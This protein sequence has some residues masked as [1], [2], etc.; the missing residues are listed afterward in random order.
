MKHTA[1]PSKPKRSLYRLIIL[2]FVSQVVIV[3]GLT[4]YL[5][6]HNGQLAVAELASQLRSEITLR[7]QQKLI[8]YMETPHLIN[9]INADAVRTGSLDI[10][11][12]DA[13]RQH[14]WQ[15]SRIKLFSN[16]VGYIGLATEE[17]NYY[18]VRRLPDG[19]T[20]FDSLI[21]L[22]GG[23]YLETWFADEAGVY[24]RTETISKNPYDPRIRP[25]YLLAQNAEKQV[26]TDVF[27]YFSGKNIAISANQPLYDTKNEFVG[28]ASTDLMLSEISDFLKGLKIGKSGKT[29]IMER[30]GKLVTSSILASPIRYDQFGKVLSDKNSKVVRWLATE[31]ENE[32]IRTAAQHLKRHFNGFEHIKGTH[33][34]QFYLDGQK[35]FIQ[36]S[37]LDDGRGLDW[38]VVVVV[39]EADFMEHIYKN[40]MTTLILAGLALIIAMIIGVF[41]AKSITKPILS[42]NEAAKKLAQGQW[43]QNLPIQRGDEIGELA[44]SFNSMGQQLKGLIEN[45]EQKVAERTQQLSKAFKSLKSSQAQLVQSEKMASLGQMVAGVAHEINTPLGYVKGNVE[46]SQ[47]LFAVV[48]ELLVEFEKLH[49]LLTQ[50]PD[51]AALAQQFAVLDELIQSFHEDDVLDDIKEL[52]LDAVHGVQEI[53]KL[54]MNLKNFSRLD[55]AHEEDVD[56][57]KCIDS[58]LNI[59]HNLLKHKVEVKLQYADLPKIVCSPSQINQVLLNIITNAAQAIEGKGIILIKTHF[60]N[61]S[62]SVLIQDNGAGIDKAHLEKIFDPFFTTKPVGEGTGLGLS[63][64]YRIIQQHKGKIK[65]TSQ[66]GKGTRFVIMLPLKTDYSS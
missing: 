31:I 50:D 13:L 51:E 19:T 6:F 8:S 18:G 2:L 41:T 40:T 12:P 1:S 62:V 24:D 26:W 27:S 11:R 39:P 5:A 17:P 52:S 54:V 14:L 55:Q 36:V 32:Q 60:T 43:E 4:G 66:V 20:K 44:T 56:L 48:E 63:I 57:N 21:T 42:L 9:Q 37:A 25:W 23:K 28:V 16:S 49:K 7:I 58:V 53:S 61:K 45:L 3:S 59:A 47:D 34:L 22:K 38:L 65:V 10:Y 29:F 64:S 35:E 15:Q 30:S 33:Q 46:T